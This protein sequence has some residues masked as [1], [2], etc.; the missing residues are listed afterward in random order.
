MAAT[1]PDLLRETVTGLFVKCG[2]DFWGVSL[3]YG[4]GESNSCKS[5]LFFM[6]FVGWEVLFDS[7]EDFGILM[8][9]W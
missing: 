3:E 2:R 5:F 6:V 7:V 9:Q 1:L 4:N 8:S